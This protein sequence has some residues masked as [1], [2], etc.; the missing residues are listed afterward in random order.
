MKKITFIGTG[1]V[2]LVSE[3]VFLILD[4]SLR[5]DISNE[6]IEC[7]KSG[8]LPIYEPGLEELVKKNVMPEDLS[9]VQ[10]FTKQWFR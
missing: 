9:L 4:T 5:V 6:K 2:G 8:K 7:L 3:H 10:T 1:Y